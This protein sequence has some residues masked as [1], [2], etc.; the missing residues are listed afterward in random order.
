M[1]GGLFSRLPRTP[2]PAQFFGIEFW[3]SRNVCR[4]AYRMLN[5]GKPRGM[6]ARS[7]K[8]RLDKAFEKELEAKGLS[9]RQE[10]SLPADSHDFARR[11]IADSGIV[12]QLSRRLERLIFNYSLKRVQHNEAEPKAETTSALKAV[13]TAARQLK[14][15]KKDDRRILKTKL[16]SRLTRPGV[17]Q[18]LV[19]MIDPR[20]IL[21]PDSSETREFEERFIANPEHSE[22]LANAGLQRGAGTRNKRHPGFRTNKLPQLDFTGELLRFWHLCLRRDI[23]LTGNEDDQSYSAT[24]YFVQKCFELAGECCT[25]EQVRMRISK[26]KK[27]MDAH[28]P[29]R[30][31]LDWAVEPTASKKQKKFS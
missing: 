15:G 21:E 3:I 20:I 13:A 7:N 4:W 28:D 2:D 30:S 19:G 27:L 11:L 26:A 12:E 10:F 17:M 9:R 22:R 1:A 6:M 16:R 24:I 14:N 8:D 31:E 18:F 23:K 25:L 5:S 29:L